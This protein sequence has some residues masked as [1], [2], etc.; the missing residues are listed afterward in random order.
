MA[1]DIFTV[2]IC[3]VLVCAISFAVFLALPEVIDL[4]VFTI[5]EIRDSVDYL[6]DVLRRDKDV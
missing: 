2:I 4:V 6:K 3:L 1:T 5:I